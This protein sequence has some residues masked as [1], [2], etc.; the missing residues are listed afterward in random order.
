MARSFLV[1]LACKV[2]MAMGGCFGAT[3][4]QVSL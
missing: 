3:H 1:Y 2:E 4:F